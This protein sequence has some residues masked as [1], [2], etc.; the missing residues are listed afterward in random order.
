MFNNTHSW[1]KTILKT[2]NKYTDN[3]KEILNNQNIDKNDD[4]KNKDKGR[5]YK[6]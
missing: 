5:G 6:T 1:K 2:A 4:V 3:I